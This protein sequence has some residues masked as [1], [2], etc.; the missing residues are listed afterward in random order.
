M[1]TKT[2][3][4][5]LLLLP[6]AGNIAAAFQGLDF[7]PSAPA[8]DSA[9]TTAIPMATNAI[10]NWADNCVQVRYGKE[11]DSSWRTPE[12]ALGPAQGT[13]S[14]ILCLGR[15]GEAVFSFPCDIADGPGPDF[16]VFENGFDDAF[17]ELAWVEVSSDGTNFV[18]FPN[19][20]YTPDPVGSYGTVDTR[21]VYGLAS[22]YR[23]GY[24]SPFDLADLQAAY[25]AQMAGNT[26]FSPAF[27]GQLTNNFPLLDL[28]RV[29]YLRLVDVVGDGSAL[30][31][32]GEPIYDPYPTSGSAGFDLDA[33]GVLHPAFLPQAY[34]DWATDHAVSPDGGG[35]AD[36]DGVVDM[37]EF[38]LGGDPTLG[39]SAPVP[40]LGTD[41]NGFVALEYT[42]DRRAAVDV[43]VAS[44]AD[45]ENWTN[46]APSRAERQVGPETVRTR[47]LFPTTATNRF[48]RLRFEAK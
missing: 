47:L 21:L 35:D 39:T 45:L 41:S 15:G 23:Q 10:V 12:K 32:R 2:K 46:A 28:H 38:A 16:A 24:G 17:L 43:S 40:A 1:N 48:F 30:D 6:M 44:S 19:Y 42:L 3:T 11:V 34:A 18:R 5:L 20:S 25:D 13:S 22:K 31:A 27:A 8:A 26:D 4:A 7:I 36:G 37:Q 33:I 14:D 29:A 9:G